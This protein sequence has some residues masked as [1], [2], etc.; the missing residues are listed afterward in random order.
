MAAQ[1][2]LL[3]AVSFNIYRIERICG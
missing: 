2:S 1:I 3:A